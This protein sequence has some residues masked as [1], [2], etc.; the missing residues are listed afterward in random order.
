MK[1]LNGGRRGRCEAEQRDPRPDRDRDACRVPHLQPAGR[2]PA[3]RSP[4]ASP[5]ATAAPTA[6]ARCASGPR[7]SASRSRSTA[8]GRRM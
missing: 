8:R 3:G 6:S 2:R 1:L 7:R 4:W 5:S